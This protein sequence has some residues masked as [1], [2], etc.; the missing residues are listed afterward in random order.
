[1]DTTHLEGRIHALATEL[2]EL[3]A[4]VGRLRAERRHRAPLLRT[5]LLIG[6]ALFAGVTW[7][8]AVSAQA[9]KENPVP[10]SVQAPFV[11]Y[12]HD[13]RPIVEIND[14]P[15]KKGLSVFG[16]PGAE[17]ASIHLA[18]GES[19]NGVGPAVILSADSK[20]AFARIDRDGY[21]FF[22]SSTNAV[23]KLGV[24]SGGKGL[25]AVYNGSG[26]PIAFLTESDKNAGGGNVTAAGPGGGGVFSAG[27]TGD[28]GNAC[29]NRGKN[30]VKCV[31][32]GLPMTFQVAK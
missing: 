13:H 9:T 26:N 6:F 12:D 28:G 20:T 7:T 2:D 30:G 23:A 19:E 4:E 16:P 31:G 8:R 11:V 15:G 10:N 18:F 3:R 27:F 32:V 17:N 25:V 1:M 22:G 29:V 14:V 5:G 21:K 24:R